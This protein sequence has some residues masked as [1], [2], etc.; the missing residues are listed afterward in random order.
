MA[1]QTPITIRQALA[2]A[3]RTGHMNR[4]MNVLHPSR[5]SRNQMLRPALMGLGASLRVSDQALGRMKRSRF[6]TIWR[7][8]QTTS[9][10]VVP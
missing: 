1:F 3:L 10:R 7:V 2:V 5:N 6:V 8:E 4:R 9:G